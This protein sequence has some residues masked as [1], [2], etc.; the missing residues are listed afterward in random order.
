M[1]TFTFSDAKSHKLWNIELTGTSFT[2]THGRIG[3]AGQSQTKTFASE[4]AA[5]KEH[6]KLVKEK[7]AKGHVEDAATTPPPAVKPQA[8]LREALEEALVADPD[9]LGNHIV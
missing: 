8:S 2:V 4:A 7:L 3:S 9:D 6:D 5:Q 1:R